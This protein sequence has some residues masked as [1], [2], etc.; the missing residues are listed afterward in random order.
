MVVGLSAAERR[1]LTDG[2]AQGLRNDGRG[3]YDFRAFSVELAIIPQANGSARV[4]L[5]ATDVITSVKAELGRP[6]ASRPSQGRVEIN[7][8]CSSTAAPQFEGRGGEDLSLELSRALYRSLLCNNGTGPAIDLSA[9]TVIEGK[10]CWNL[11]IDGLVLSSD[12]NLLDV[13]AIAVK[14]ALSNTGIPK[15]EVTSAA[16]AEQE[17]DFEISDNPDDFSGFDVSHVPVIITLTKVGRTY[18]VDATEEEESQ[19]SSAISIA[20]NSAGHVCGI[21]KRGGAGLDPSV[22]LD[23][24]SVAKE[25]SKSLLSTV[26]AEIMAAESRGDDQM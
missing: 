22:L 7:I 15:V 2:I 26:D 1:Y 8:E 18:I 21:T 3:L 19:M 17:A 25:V 20:V 14:A 6:Q 13:L 9:L 16:A 4:R 10:L 11:F 23:M 5:G 24:I 12:G